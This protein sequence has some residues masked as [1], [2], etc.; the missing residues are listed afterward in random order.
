[1]DDEDN[2]GEMAVSKE[3]LYG[4][5]VLSSGAASYA[6]TYTDAVNMDDRWT[7]KY[8]VVCGV[9][10]WFL[11]ISMGFLQTQWSLILSRP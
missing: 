7:L 10:H 1:M 11:L 4:V 8:G 3:T 2:V 6:E 5:N 9:L